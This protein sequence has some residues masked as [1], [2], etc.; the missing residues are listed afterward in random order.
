M[1]LHHFSRDSNNCISDFQLKPVHICNLSLVQFYLKSTAQVVLCETLS[2][3]SSGNENLTTVLIWLQA[4]LGYK[5]RPQ[6]S[7]LKN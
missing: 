7:H 4:D 3:N 1:E 5:P 6:T 2:N